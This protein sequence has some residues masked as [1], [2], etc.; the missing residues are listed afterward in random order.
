M[1]DN[2]EELVSIPV[3]VLERLGVAAVVY[4]SADP[5][6]IRAR[7]QSDSTRRW[8]ELDEAELSRLQEMG[9]AARSS[10]SVKLGC[11]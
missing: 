6:Q 5:G 11:P 10:Y 1:I 7:R 8:P 3:G 2:G 9:L 4:L